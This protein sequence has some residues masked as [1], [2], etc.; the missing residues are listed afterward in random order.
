MLKTFPFPLS[1]TDTFQISFQA[2]FN[3]FPQKIIG[4]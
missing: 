4:I 1:V 3:I 2:I